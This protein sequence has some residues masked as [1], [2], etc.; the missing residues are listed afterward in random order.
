[1]TSTPA[2]NSASAVET[3]R[4]MPPARF[5]PFA[6]TK[7]AR[8]CSRSS[9]SVCSTAPR[10]GL[11]ITSPIMITRHAPGGRAVFEWGGFPSVATTVSFGLPAGL[12]G[13][14]HGSGLADHGD[15]DLAR[16]RQRF[17]D[18]ADD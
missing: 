10:P 4:P 17:L 9:G 7:S 15:L 12:F 14:L 16:V 18:L 3:V 8:R 6:V 1:M 2:W 13:V 11:P 5:S